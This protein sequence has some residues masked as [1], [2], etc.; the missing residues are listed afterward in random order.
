MS[1]RETAKK[2]A[3]AKKI[4]PWEIVQIAR[5]AGR[6]VISDFIAGMCSDFVE[7]HGDRAF[8]DDQGMIG[9]F[10]TIGGERVMLMGQRK[11]KTVDENIA[12]NFGMANPE[13]YRKALRL[14]KLAEKYGL[15]VVSLVDTPGAYPGLDAEARGQAEAIARNLTEMAGLRTPVIVVVTGEGG[16]GGALGIAV[17][18]VVMMLQNAIYSVISP[19]GCASILWRDGTK[20]PDAAAALK[21]TAESLLKLGVIDEVIAEPAGAAH[22]DPAKTIEAVKK[23][24][25]KWLVEL[26]KIDT[27][28]LVQRRYDKFAAMGR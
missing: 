5:D 25:L 13:G 9:G 26:K 6:P 2:K 21:I 24:V 17:G 18:D 22:S 19:E 28:T 16:S 12:Y 27:D 8:G 23:A 15:P 3:V 4:T 11:G 1:K 10:A 14:M 20:A 7:L